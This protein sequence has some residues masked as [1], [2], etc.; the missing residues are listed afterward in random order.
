M[1]RGVGVSHAVGGTNR[2]VARVSVGRITTKAAAGWAS[3]ELIYSQSN[4]PP[5]IRITASD[6][7]RIMVQRVKAGVNLGEEVLNPGPRIPAGMATRC[8]VNT[9]QVV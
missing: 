7:Y 9:G 4:V 8:P 3:S 2:W 1:G 5:T 6:V